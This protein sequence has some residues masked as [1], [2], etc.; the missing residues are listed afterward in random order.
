[1]A[2]N[3][4]PV[5]PELR[6]RAR[7]F[8]RIPFNRWNVRFFQ[9]LTRLQPESKAPDDIQIDQLYVQSQDQ[10]HRIGLRVYRPKAM[11][12]DA[13]VLLWICLLYTSRRGDAARRSEEAPPQP[14]GQVVDQ[15]RGLLQR[16]G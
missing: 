8:P 4:T 3:L 7:T 6:Q 16:A 12:P 9:W 11:N 5:H 13:P 14:G 15:G 2:R 10:Q 1:M